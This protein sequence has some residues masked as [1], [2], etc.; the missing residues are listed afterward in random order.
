M[1]EM[2]DLYTADRKKAKGTYIRGKKHPEG[3]YSMVC[4]VCI[5]NSRNQMLLQQKSDRKNKNNIW[6][7][8]AG[9][10]SLAGETSREAMTRELYEEIGISYD[11]SNET[12]FLTTYYKDCF[13][14]V[15]IL[16]NFD[17]DAS[18]LVLQEAEVKDV[19]WATKEEI[20]SLIDKKKFLPFTKDYIELLFFLNQNGKGF[21]KNN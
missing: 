16:R 21:V 18:T 13:D 2:I 8:S 11:F 4:H 19:M 7:F 20:F 10:C 12:P 14:D 6:D 1:P 15:Y 17:I 5:F 9:G 3:L